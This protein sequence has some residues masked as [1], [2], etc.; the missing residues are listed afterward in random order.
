MG[1]AVVCMSQCISQNTSIML[2]LMVRLIIEGYLLGWQNFSQTMT[3]A[4]SCNF[5]LCFF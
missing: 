1:H 5:P 3:M 4:S 2:F